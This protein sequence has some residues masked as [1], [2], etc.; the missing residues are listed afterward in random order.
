MCDDDKTS[1]VHH[2]TFV[3][4]IFYFKYC[5]VLNFLENLKRNLFEIKKKLYI[6]IIFFS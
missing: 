6:N 3:Y 5:R 2:V 1:D 4:Y